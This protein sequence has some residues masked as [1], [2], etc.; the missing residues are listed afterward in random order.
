M[1]SVSVTA[2]TAMEADALSTAGFVL[3]EAEG[4]ELFQ[5]FSGVEGLFIKE[6]PERNLSFHPTSG[7]SPSE[8]SYSQSRRRFLALLSSLFIGLIV[9]FRAQ[10]AVVYATEE[11]ALRKMMPDADR[12]DTDEIDLSPDQLSR[13]QTSAGKGF[14]EKRFRFRV[15]RKGEEAV[16]YAILLEVIGKERPITFLIGIEPNGVVKG[17]EVLIYR[18]SEGSEIRHPRF[19]AQFLKKKMEDPLRAGQDIQ[20][21]SGATLSSR[22]AAY[23]VRKALSIFEVVYKKKAESR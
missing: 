17:A 5:R 14:R 15:G 1:A 13:A 12:F 6:D 10:A 8:G 20:I 18:E 9:P 11:E 22:A 19:M 7:W 16:G 23:A 21:I 2:P 3:G 4:R